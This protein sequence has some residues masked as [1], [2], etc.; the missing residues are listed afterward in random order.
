MKEAE[1]EGHVDEYLSAFLW[2]PVFLKDLFL[3]V[4]VAILIVPCG[5]IYLLLYWH[6]PTREAIWNFS[7]RI[8]NSLGYRVGKIKRDAG[9]TPKQNNTALRKV[10]DGAKKYEKGW[11]AASLAYLFSR[12][13]KVSRGLGAAAL[14]SAGVRKKRELDRKR[15]TELPKDDEPQNPD[16]ELRLLAYPDEVPPVIGGDDETGEQRDP[17]DA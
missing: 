10:Y 15:Q 2:I 13:S 17:G 7:Q 8:K 12:K 14:A 11:F 1:D 9:E 16:E 3:A 6:K 5:W 4:F